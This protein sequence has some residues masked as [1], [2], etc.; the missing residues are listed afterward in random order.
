[1]PHVVHAT[2]EPT[3]TAPDVFARFFGPRADHVMNP[4]ASTTT[5]LDTIAPPTYLYKFLGLVSV[6]EAGSW[7]MAIGIALSAYNATGGQE[8]LACGRLG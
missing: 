5:V 4:F 6:S 7:D 8:W 1:M 3:R 2:L